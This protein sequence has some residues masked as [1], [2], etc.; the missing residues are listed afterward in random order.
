MLPKDSPFAPGA[1]IHGMYRIERVLAEGAMGVV[2]AATH[3]GIGKPVALKVLRADRRTKEI[4]ARFVREAEIAMRLSGDHLA[5]VT[6]SG[7][8]EDGAPF[9]VMELLEGRDLA[10]E[11]ATRGPLPIAEA[12]DM[13]LEACA[14]VA[15]AH[16]VGLVHRDLKPANLFVV[17]RNDGGDLV[18]VL[19]FG[20]AKLRDGAEGADA[21]GAGGPVTG[22]GKL[23]GTPGFT[24]PEQARGE[25]DI[26]QRADIYALGAILY[27][28]LSGARAH[29]GENYN[30]IL[31]HILTQPVVP[32]GSACRPA[33]STWSTAPC[34]PS[35][36]NATRA[37]M[38]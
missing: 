16:A 36:R 32:L 21:A 10:A 11:L 31:F 25:R 6:S 14:G 5:R 30:A 17:R 24:P 28:L 29:P 2:L 38:I 35:A 15:E 12:V 23:L 34:P 8:A 33:W 19:D 1:L 37:R 18:K 27:E 4:E 9:L 26:D 3:V 22:T 7:Y 13:V 20:I